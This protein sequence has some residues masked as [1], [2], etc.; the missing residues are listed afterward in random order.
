[1]TTPTPIPGSLAD[2]LEKKQ[3][4]EGDV[5]SL[6]HLRD[7]LA[8]ALV[9]MEQN[10]DR[11]TAWL[12]EKRESII[13]TRHQLM[14]AIS[15]KN[16]A[17][18]QELL[19]NS[20]K[21]S[22]SKDVI[23]FLLTDGVIIEQAQK[24]FGEKHHL[25]AT[26]RDHTKGLP[27][28]LIEMLPSLDVPEDISKNIA[29][30]QSTLAAGEATVKP[31]PA[32]NKGGALSGWF[33]SQAQ[34]DTE[35]AEAAYFGMLEHWRQIQRDLIG[36]QSDRHYYIDSFMDWVGENL[37][38]S[39]ADQNFAALM[40]QYRH[41]AYVIAR[42]QED[43]NHALTGRTKAL[44]D[45]ANT[46]SHV[47]R[48]LDEQRIGDFIG[49]MPT[50]FPKPDQPAAAEMRRLLLADF[51]ASSF[52]DIALDYVTDPAARYALLGASVAHE[53][54]LMI[55]GSMSANTLFARIFDE[56]TKAGDDV[57]PIDALTLTMRIISRR[58][59]DVN[60][61]SYVREQ[62]IIGKLT[63]R[64]GDDDAAYEQALTALF[65]GIDANCATTHIG[66][67][68]TLR[69]AAIERDSTA[70]A[71]A[72]SAINS[73][74]DAA[75]VRALWDLVMRGT[76]NT[77]I[78]LTQILQ[79]S[80]KGNA[81]TLVPLLSQALALGLAREITLEGLSSTRDGEVMKN[82]TELI[83]KLL[84]DSMID[85]VAP[86]AITMLLAGARI[87]KNTDASK[88]WQA[89]LSGTK[90]II[91]T[92]ARK[93]SLDNG[94]KAAFIAALMS[95]YKDAIKTTAL[96]ENIASDIVA[97]HGDQ[98]GVDLLRD[99]ARAII[100]DVF[101]IEN[102][103]HLINPQNIA[104]IWYEPQTDA[105]GTL[106]FTLGG[107]TH[108]LTSRISEESAR[109][110][111]DI[112]YHRHGFMRE[113][114]G[115]FN[116]DSAD[117][118]EHNS[119]DGTRI[120]WDMHVTWL[121]I[122]P[123]QRAELQQRK[124]MIHADGAD[125]AISMRPSAVLALIPMPGQWLLVDRNGSHQLV[126]NLSMPNDETPLVRM[127]N[128]YINPQRA[129][130]LSIDNGDQSISLRVENPIF[131]QLVEAMTRQD[132]LS[133]YSSEGQYIKVGATS[134]AQWNACMA[135][136]DSDPAQLSPGG[137]L[138]H[139]RFNL[140]T[141]GFITA[142]A[143]SKSAGIQ[144]SNQDKGGLSGRIEVDGE[145][146]PELIAGL[147]K[148]ASGR[149]N[150]IVIENSSPLSA[151]IVH[152]DQAHNIFYNADRAALMILTEHSNLSPGL[153][154]HV[155]TRIIKQCAQQPGWESLDNRSQTLD[156]ARMDRATLLYWDKT[157][158]SANTLIGN[159]VIA[160]GMTQS[161]FERYTAKRAADGQ[162]PIASALTTAQMKDFALS[163]ANPGMRAADLPPPRKSA[164]P[165]D[166]LDVVTTVK[167]TSARDQKYIEQKE[168]QEILRSKENKNSYN[169][170]YKSSPKYK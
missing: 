27:A 117:G 45:D 12:K 94:K 87:E 18:L 59:S 134:K 98:T 91:A 133:A 7:Q 67:F 42:A 166:L 6:S 158:G 53:G 100:G 60:F 75:P 49:D 51:G 106:A 164:H 129:S 17:N 22:A 143:D 36:M 109:E 81:K 10:T 54:R 1:M 122:T 70:L 28:R 47:V 138:G 35:E 34:R 128:T 160:M 2:L 40:T 97:A 124:D 147:Q 108:V 20:G 103:R 73:A 144:Y 96:L 16:V 146:V 14:R 41:P 90:G 5:Q 168:Y 112:L 142:Y 163:C 89:Q 104:N 116:P 37:S 135:A 3:S 76:S 136:I 123:A 159:R 39:T 88:N 137:D 21:D 118:F 31:A 61:N 110:L 23:G 69:R 170:K 140:D 153:S 125:G 169:N 55:K 85:D 68:V 149:D 93:A 107:K 48:A 121:N 148:A 99:S 102:N 46:Y 162:A 57:L 52:A 56:V 32:K 8:L 79:D 9:T 155:A 26:L 114:M 62:D 66:Q 33:K 156:I 161:D 105:T 82:V 65:T 4:L 80:A 64:F 30:M 167:S 24:A 63:A 130:L 145:L 115:L 86:A 43:Y 74:E 119:K 13:V 150:A 50:L 11:I 165:R 120:I 77:G 131:T 58:N 127:G 25:V 92:I 152:A 132:E 154:S 29:Q 38:P 83:G 78:S 71:S 113:K 95:P 141:L 72:M 139:L 15:N 19:A 151:L 126:K 84:S 101:T 157:D 44:L 111:F